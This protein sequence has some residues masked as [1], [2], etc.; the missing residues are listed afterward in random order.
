MSLIMQVAQLKLPSSMCSVL[1]L[2]MMRSKTSSGM[3]AHISPICLGFLRCCLIGAGRCHPYS[4]LLGCESHEPKLVR[5]LLAGVRIPDS[6]LSL[7]KTELP[8]ELLLEGR[9][10]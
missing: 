6:L 3:A 4:G 9:L 1:K 5:W 8:L 7:D 2:L 10:I